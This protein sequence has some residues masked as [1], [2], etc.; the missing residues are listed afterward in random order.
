MRSDQES[1]VANE[2]LNI[3]LV[4]ISSKKLKVLIS[5]LSIVV[6]GLG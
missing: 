6:L 2:P 5:Q 4:S 3:V 1:T